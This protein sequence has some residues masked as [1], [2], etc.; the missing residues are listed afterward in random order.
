MGQFG[1]NIVAFPFF[2]LGSKLVVPKK[3]SDP[4]LKFVGEKEVQTFAGFSGTMVFETLV[5]LLRD[6]GTAE[7]IHWVEGGFYSGSVNQNYLPS[8]TGS[9]P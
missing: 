2:E 3:T 5:K 9:F 7:R 1:L 4:E 6:F 8:A